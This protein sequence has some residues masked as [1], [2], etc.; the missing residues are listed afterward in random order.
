M[1]DSRSSS[2]CVCVCVCVLGRGP[3]QSHKYC[4]KCIL[5]TR[6]P[7]YILRCVSSFACSLSHFSHVQLYVTLWTIALQATLSMGILQAR[8]L[9]WTAMPSSRGSSLPRDRTCIS[10]PL[11]WWAG[12]LPLASPGKPRSPAFQL[13][14]LAAES[15]GKPSLPFLSLYYH[16]PAWH[17]FL[18]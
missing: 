14:S 4:N 11:H 17:L 9:E 6:S 8:I 15:T 13:Y 7:V 5:Y 1:N 12:S 10:R 2:V 16:V 3:L 18:T